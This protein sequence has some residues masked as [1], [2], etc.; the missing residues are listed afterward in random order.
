MLLVEGELRTSSDVRSRNLVLQPVR[1]E[2]VDS[3]VANGESIGRRATGFAYVE[4]NA[5][6]EE[7]GVSLRATR[8]VTALE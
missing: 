7:K 1:R 3:C 4:A 8:R 2:S 6:W 5:A